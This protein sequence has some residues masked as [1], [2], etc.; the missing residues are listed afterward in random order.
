VKTTFAVA[1]IRRAAAPEIVIAPE[2]SVA[3]PVQ[4]GPAHPPV[5]SRRCVGEATS[6]HTL[7]FREIAS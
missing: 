7:V 5:L 1:L 2:P 4:I 3:G 6:T